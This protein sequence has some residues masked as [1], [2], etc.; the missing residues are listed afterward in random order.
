M[1]LFA[2]SAFLILYFYPMGNFFLYF[3]CG[4]VS[5]YSTLTFPTIPGH[6]NRHVTQAV[7]CLFLAGYMFLAGQSSVIQS[8]VLRNLWG[9]I[10]LLQFQAKMMWAWN[11][12]Q[13]CCLLAWREMVRRETVLGPEEPRGWQSDGLILWSGFVLNNMYLWTSRVQEPIKLL[14]TWVNPSCFLIAALEVVIICSNDLLKPRPSEFRLTVTVLKKY[15]HDTLSSAT[16]CSIINLSC[17][18]SLW[19]AQ[20]CFLR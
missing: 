9:N 10:F 3:F 12:Q 11:H 4:A 2:F 8:I 20:S 19:Q 5:S 13:S 15:N 6:K 7:L 18:T 1:F 17:G 14:F 16:R